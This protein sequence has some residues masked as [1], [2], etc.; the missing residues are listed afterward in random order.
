MEGTNAFSAEGVA[1]AAGVVAEGDESEVGRCK[2]DLSLSSVEE[3]GRVV[4]EGAAVGSAAIAGAAGVVGVGEGA[5]EGVV[6]DMAGSC[7]G[8]EGV[9]V[10]RRALEDFMSE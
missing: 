10:E 4:A 8:V 5:I 6:I 2:M 9:E 1:V 3:R 7:V